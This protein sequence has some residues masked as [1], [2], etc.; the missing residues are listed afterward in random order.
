MPSHFSCK[1]YEP[2]KLARWWIL[3]AS[4]VM[5]LTGLAHTL[6]YKFVI[7]EVLKSNLPAD[8]IGAFKA[9]WLIYSAHLILLS[10]V[11]A[12]IGRLPGTRS[13]VLFLALFPISDAIFMYH[14]VGPFIGLYMVLT[15]AVLLLIGGWLLPRSENP[16]P[17]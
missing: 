17:G 5:F 2:M 12:W 3:L 6:G 7:S 4:V 11:I 16:A 8:I 14:F 13:L 1:E 9:V 15:A 10:G